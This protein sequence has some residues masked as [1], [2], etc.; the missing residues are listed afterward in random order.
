MSKIERQYI[1][2]GS[3]CRGRD[4]WWARR[5]RLGRGTTRGSRRARA[6]THQEYVRVPLRVRVIPKYTH[7]RLPEPHHVTE[8]LN[9]FGADDAGS[10]GRVEREGG[11]GGGF[12][13]RRSPTKLGLSR[14]IRRRSTSLGPLAASSRAR[15][16]QS[17][18][19]RFFHLLGGRRG[20][21]L[22][23][24]D[25]GPR[26]G[27][28]RGGVAR[29]AA[30]VWTVARATRSTRGIRAGGHVGRHRDVA[31]LGGPQR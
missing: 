14:A 19:A 20:A 17:R 5:S 27:R 28:S 24:G 30:S 23:R 7:A 12:D 9:A 25:G 22:G 21:L 29:A 16:R 6:R 2:L 11:G 1:V 15:R 8:A 13:Q 10:R 18:R 4:R 3:N 31:P 26:R